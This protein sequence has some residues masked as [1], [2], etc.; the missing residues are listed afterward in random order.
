[1]AVLID[2]DV[3]V[4]YLSKR[5]PFYSDAFRI[6]EL[7]KRQKFFGVISTQTYA[8]L[9]YVL[10]R[11]LSEELRREL[12]LELCLLFGIGVIDG[13]MTVRALKESQYKDFEDRLQMLCALSVGADYI[14]TRNIK[15]YNDSEIKAVSPKEFLEI[16]EKES[17]N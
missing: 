17:E 15:D 2:T 4:D 1:M 7:R 12:L 14:V 13:S 6:I 16:L 8:N 5:E 9:Y 3:L 11:V 10:R